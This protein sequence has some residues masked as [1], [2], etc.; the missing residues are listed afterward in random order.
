MK[1][2]DSIKSIQQW[3]A[4]VAHALVSI[5]VVYDPHSKSTE[6]LM[7]MFEYCIGSIMF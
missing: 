7:T 6:S 4:H 3:Q 5:K 2:N 1:L